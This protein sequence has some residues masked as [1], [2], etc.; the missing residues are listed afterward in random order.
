MVHLTQMNC[1]VYELCLQKMLLWKDFITRSN[2]PC[3]CLK[4]GI[5]C[6]TLRILFK[7]VLLGPR[8]CTSSKQ[9]IL[10]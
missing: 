1:M 6:S 4:C 8:I 9:V 3:P 10:M 7:W 2:H 5:L